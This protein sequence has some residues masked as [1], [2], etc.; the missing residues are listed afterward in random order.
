MTTNFVLRQPKA[1]TATPLSIRLT[2]KNHSVLFSTGVKINPTYLLENNFR[3]KDARI[4][5]RLENADILNDSINSRRDKLENSFNRYVSKYGI[6]PQTT[7]DFKRFLDSESERIANEQREEDKKRINLLDYFE[8]IAQRNDKR[9]E[10]LGKLSNRNSISTS[11]RQTAKVL[12]AFES[13]FVSYKV[14]FDRIDLDFYADFLDY[15]NEIRM[16]SVNNTGKR[17]EILALLVCLVLSR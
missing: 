3:N 12:R 16:Y 14:N 11:Y 13:D 7:R 2:W 6:E 9:L 17:R 10:A 8:I 15:C 1:K 5:N 4:S